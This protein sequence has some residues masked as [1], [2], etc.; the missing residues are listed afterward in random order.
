[1]T[2]NS[3][4][5]AIIGLMGV[6]KSTI[7]SKLAEQMGYYFVDSDQEIEDFAKSSISQIFTQKGEKYFRDIE[8]DIIRQI[9]DRDERIVLSLGGGAFD[10]EQTREML[11]KKAFVIYFKAPVDVILHRIGG[12]TNRP[13]LNNGNKRQILEDLI[14]KRSP[15]Y[16]QADLA[17]DTSQKTHEEIISQILE[18]F[19]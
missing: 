12:K 8:K 3:E 15:N 6:G 18:N 1:M 5:I 19:S 16:V 14:E 13:L 10:D 7:G 4:I 11:L 2:K 9:V 17:I